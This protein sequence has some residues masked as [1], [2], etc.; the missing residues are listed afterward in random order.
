MD[1]SAV[2]ENWVNFIKN[3]KQLKITKALAQYQKN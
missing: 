1:G 3:K 2:A